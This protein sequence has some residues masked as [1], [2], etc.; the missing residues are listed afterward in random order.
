[1]VEPSPLTE[2]F[3]ALSRARASE[4]AGRERRRKVVRTIPWLARVVLGVLPV[5]ST[6]LIALWIVCHSAFY[7]LVVPQQGA[8]AVHAVLA[9]AAVL[10][11]T[12]PIGRDRR[13]SSVALGVSAGLVVVYAI[14]AAVILLFLGFTLPEIL[15]SMICG[16][17]PSM[18]LLPFVLVVATPLSLVA[19]CA[20]DV[21]RDV[22]A[23]RGRAFGF[24]DCGWILLGLLPTYA[25]ALG[26]GAL[27]SV[28]FVR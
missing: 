9:G 6:V 14:P 28:L 12:R 1:M 4:R 15:P 27:W 2:G 11:H 5:W 3:E 8:Q 25:S 20:R 18:S 26:S 17:L 24:R 13:I 7:G 10:P 16:E 23:L 22:S 21:A 19:C